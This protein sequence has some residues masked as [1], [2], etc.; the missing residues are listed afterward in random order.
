MASGLVTAI[1]IAM[2]QPAIFDP[3]V[4][5]FRY[6]FFCTFFNIVTA[7]KASGFAFGV[8]AV[9]SAVRPLN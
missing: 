8:W 3:E 9:F 4:F 6:V 5:D 7:A 2:L 1:C